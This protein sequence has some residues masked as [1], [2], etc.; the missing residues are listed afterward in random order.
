VKTAVSVPAD[1]RLTKNGA[2]LGFNFTSANGVTYT[3]WQSDT[4]AAGSWTNTG[5][6]AVTGDGTA[7]TMTLPAPNTSVP[8]RYYRLQVQ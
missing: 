2:N 5:L 6:P 3:L 1:F 8:K 7:K 4:L